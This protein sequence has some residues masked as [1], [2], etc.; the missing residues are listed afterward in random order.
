MSET[1]TTELYPILPHPNSTAPAS[2]YN[3]GLREMTTD[4]APQLSDDDVVRLC[5]KGKEEAFRSLYYRYRTRIYSFTMTILRN[6]SDA[7]DALQEVFRYIFSKI[8]AYRP[9]GRFKS[10]I[11]KIAHSVSID[12]V[13]KRSRQASIPEDYD[14][15]SET[16]EPPHSEE[17]DQLRACIARL[18]SMYR[19]VMVLRLIDDLAYEEIAEVLS[20]PLGTIKSRI[21]HSVMLIRRMLKQLRGESATEPWSEPPEENRE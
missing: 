1:K 13:R 2:L 8:Q 7:E 17:L 4:T 12:I 10:F 14:I 3:K 9:E 16:A 15:P 6:P 18:P 19:E 20:L 5:Q 11:F 21:H